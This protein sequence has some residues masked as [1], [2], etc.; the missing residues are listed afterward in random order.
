[1]IPTSDLAD[2]A[3]ARI[4]VITVGASITPTQSRLDIKG[5]VP[6]LLALM[7][8]LDY[9][10]P[11]AIVVVVSNPVDVLTRVAIET[12]RRP[13]TRV[14]GTGTVLDTARLR[15]ALANVVQADP[16]NVHAYVVGEHGDS[17]VVLWSA[18][19]IGPVPLAAYPLPDGLT[20]PA[21][22][23]RCSERTR[24]RGLEILGRLGNTTFGIAGAVHRIADA[25]LHNQRRILTVSTSTPPEYGLA[26]TATLSIP[27]V[28][29]AT[30]VARR[31]VVPRDH[32]EQQQLERSGE[33]L[34]RAYANLKDERS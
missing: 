4:V 28:V 27:S 12:T 29:G 16:H 13:A 11:E 26:P 15:R 22:R 5:N 20:L 25:V 3:G 14:L 23:E 8:S 2:V 30:G 21:V 9:L 10:A 24:Q 32:L 19:T 34:E 7:R 18:A 1:V 33:T 31:L 6:L 17:S